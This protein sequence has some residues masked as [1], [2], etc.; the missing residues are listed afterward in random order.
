[1]TKK[2]ITKYWR[3]SFATFLMTGLLAFSG[4]SQF[5]T[6]W[7]TDNSG[8]SNNNQIT[9]PG[10]GN[11]TVAWEQVND[12]SVNGSINALDAVTITLPSA[13]TYKISITGGLNQVVFAFSGDKQKLLSIEQWGNISWTSMERAF[14]GCNNMTYNATDTPDLSQVTSL[15]LMF[16]GCIKFNGNIDNWNT[17]NITDMGEMFSGADAFN[18]PIGQWNTS[19]VTTMESMFS[20]ADKF[21]QPIGDWDVSKVT[22]MDNMFRGAKAFNQP[23]GDWDVSE[24][25]TMQYMFQEARAFNQP[26]G[27]WV[28]SK[29][30]NMASMFENAKAFNQPI[31]NWDVRQ[32]TDMSQMFAFFATL[33]DAT[34][35]KV[36]QR[37]S[38]NNSSFNQPLNNWKTDNV[39]TL[40]Y[41]FSGAD[42]FNQPLNNWFT[43]KVSS[44]SNM[45]Q[46]AT[47]F[48][49]NLGDWNITEVTSML[50][51]LSNAGLS[52]GN[53][54]RTLTGWAG[55]FVK[56][57]VRLGATGIKY[58]AAEASRNTLVNSKNWTITGDAKECPLNDIEVQLDGVE[59]SSGSVVDFGTTRSL[60]K[61]FTI[62]N[63]GVTSAIV[64][65]GAPLIR[66]TSGT[67]FAVIE[68]PN[69]STVAPGGSL[70][71]KVTYTAATSND[72]GT[73]SISSNDPDEATYTI[74]LK[75]VLEKQN[76][77][78][79]FNLGFDLT[80]TFGDAN[81]DL[82]ATGGASGNAVTFTS[83]NTNVAT[84]VGKTVTI[85]GVGTT[86]ITASQAGNDFYNAAADVTQILAVN[87]G[88]QTITFDLGN[89]ANKTL[90]AANF[91]LTATGGASG[92]AV[93]FTSSD[94][95]VAT[96][97]GTTV[98]IVGIGTTT[99]TASQLGNDNYKAAVEVT[100]TLT[101]QNTITSLPQQLNSSKI[102]VFPN[103]ISD[104]LRI[105]MP[106]KPSYNY[107][108]ITILNQQGKR[109]MFMGQTIKNGQVEIPVET[110]ALGQYLLQ[111]SAGGE[112][113][114]RRIVKL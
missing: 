40:S 107:V 27:N 104:M 69:A 98:T 109:V 55:Q 75:G 14:N 25:T 60:T 20:S 59:I 8:T 26:I 73:I 97:S 44:M 9:I 101:V 38:G 43:G 21:N 68:Q 39:T 5:I 58:C 76:Q 85:V 96:V 88:N 93:T 110:L 91:D 30:T 52:L 31:G 48:N 114:M 32:V 41:M 57:N 2:T 53:Y 24:V 70:T 99:I 37:T 46:G 86:T 51:M 84:V 81:F 100:Q 90:G 95:S 19:Q 16:A 47:N 10:R 71:F 72:L 54:D 45:F 105:K 7:K 112:T 50:S 83:S 80:K 42:S 12:P 89:N 3:I 34:Q 78:I 65:S 103:P 61:T 33:A 63:I 56:T 79:V 36:R 22:V 1:M 23:I 106:Q 67:S 13:G 111:I 87:K 108:E 29:V 62:H 92:N 35:D 4:Y 18:Q 64:L 102:I 11:Y 15:R 94:P 77:N 17:G 74:E 49:Q 66:I 6:T 113:I 28:V 82:N